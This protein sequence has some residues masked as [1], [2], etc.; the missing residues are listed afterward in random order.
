MAHSLLGVTEDDIKGTNVFYTGFEFTFC[1]F[2][3][4]LVLPGVK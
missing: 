4:T 1:L 2:Y 3:A